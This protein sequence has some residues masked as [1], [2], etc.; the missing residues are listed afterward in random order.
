MNNLKIKVFGKEVTR[1]EFVVNILLTVVV[2]VCLLVFLFHTDWYLAGSLKE[3]N[4]IL[5]KKKLLLAIGTFAAGIGLI[6]CP[7]H[8]RKTSAHGPGIQYPFYGAAPFCDLFYYRFYRTLH[9]EHFFKK[10]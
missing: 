5:S 4:L 10:T 9:A 8:H 7:K 3:N 1:R 2:L 6:Y